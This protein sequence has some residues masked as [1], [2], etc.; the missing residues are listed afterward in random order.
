MKFVD[1]IE[2]KG[3]NNTLIWKYPEEDFNT[4]S[5]LVV[6]ESQ[7]AV[8]FLNGKAL[9]LFQPGKVTLHTSNIPLL[10]KIV[11]LPFGGESPFKCEV[12]FINKTEKMTINWGAGDINYLDP[13]HNDYAF[14]I[15][16]NGTMSIRINDSRK[17]ISKLVGTE[18]IRDDGTMLDRETI[19]EYFKVPIRTH[20]RTLLPRLLREKKVSIFEVESNLTEYAEILKERISIEMADYGISLEKFWIE[21]II[22]PEKDP[23]YVKLNRYRGDK[24]TLVNDGILA[25]IQ[26]E[27][28]SKVKLIEHAGKVQRQMMDTDAKANDANKL[29][30]TV[31]QEWGFEVLKEAAKNEGAGSDFRNSM[32]GLTMG[33]GMNSAFGSAITNIANEILPP[34]ITESTK[35]SQSVKSEDVPGMIELKDASVS[36]EEVGN[37]NVSDF[38]MRIEMLDMMRNKG[39]LPDEEFE[40]CRKELLNEIMKKY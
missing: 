37:L 2:Y 29:G 1:V 10:N 15:G 20:I 30:Y 27:N 9:D 6:R 17:I 8:L 36:L 7:E 22:K 5:Q 21:T 11:N 14:K 13:T 34:N 23:V 33:V 19:G 3:N 24:V 4:L 40:K 32:L 16:A 12:Y 26:A 35:N 25:E 39:M 38:N 31:Q 18:I 28:I